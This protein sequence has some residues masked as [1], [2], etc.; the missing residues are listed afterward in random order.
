MHG[1]HAHL[2]FLSR[3]LLA[4]AIV[5]SVSGLLLGFLLLVGGIILLTVLV[6]GRSGLVVLGLLGFAQRHL[7]F[8]LHL[9]THVVFVALFV[10]LLHVVSRREHLVLGHRAASVASCP[11]FTLSFAF[12]SS[13]LVE[14]RVQL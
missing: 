9:L 2:A 4:L 1:Y 13:T 6:V 12:F 5:L 10:D 3:S 7:L 14:G 11:L 8:G